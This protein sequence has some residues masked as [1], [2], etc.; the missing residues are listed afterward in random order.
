MCHV[1]ET[2]PLVIFSLKLDKHPCIVVPLSERSLETLD[3][4]ILANDFPR[5]RARC[6]YIPLVPHTWGEP[7]FYSRLKEGFA[8]HLLQGWPFYSST[9]HSDGRLKLLGGHPRRDLDPSMEVDFR[10][11][12]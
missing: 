11:I 7:S 9:R 8:D 3:F 6:T 12:S 10:W 5:T 1:L 4:M 2:R